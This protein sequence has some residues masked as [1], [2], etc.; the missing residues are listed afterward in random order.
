MLWCLIENM[1]DCLLIMAV[2]SGIMQLESAADDLSSSND[3]IAN[4]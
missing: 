1:E 4:V 3:D 2:F